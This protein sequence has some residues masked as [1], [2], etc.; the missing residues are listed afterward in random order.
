M[1]VVA[2]GHDSVHVVWCYETRTPNLLRSKS[3]VGGYSQGKHGKGIFWICDR[4]E[5]RRGESAHAQP[6]L[7]GDC[8]TGVRVMRR[9]AQ[10][11]VFVAKGALPMERCV[12]PWNR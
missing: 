5:T 2:A 12:V 6:L 3:E 10:P 8:R 4:E 1:D 7:T 9:F 11:Q